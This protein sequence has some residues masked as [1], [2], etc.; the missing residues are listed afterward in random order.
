MTISSPTCRTHGRTFQTNYCM[1]THSSCIIKSLP[2]WQVKYAKHVSTEKRRSPASRQTLTASECR[3]LL[4]RW[5]PVWCGKRCEVV[6]KAPECQTHLWS[7]NTTE[8]GNVT[9]GR[10]VLLNNNTNT[11]NSNNTSIM[12][13]RCILTWFLLFLVNLLLFINY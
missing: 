13:K 4:W 1:H 3:I 5:Q 8:Y 9:Q 7:N 12:W 11:T 2:S 6:H 10:G